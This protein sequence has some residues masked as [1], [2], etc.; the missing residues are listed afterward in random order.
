[1][2]LLLP[3][4]LC[5]TTGPFRDALN[6]PSATRDT[7]YQ[8]CLWDSCLKQGFQNDG[9]CESIAAY[10]VYVSGQNVFHENWRSVAPE[11]GKCTQ[12]FSCTQLPFL[13][14]LG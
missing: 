14:Y 13:R 7:Y 8:D 9:H 12:Q 11:C 4:C 6:L 5:S 10:A 2:F 1:M 3:P